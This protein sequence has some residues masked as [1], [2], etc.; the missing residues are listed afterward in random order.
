MKKALSFI[1]ALAM[2][3]CLS[4]TAFAAS[5]DQTGSTSITA[6]VVGPT[7]TIHVPAA[8]TLD[9]TDTGIQ[10]V[11]EVYID[12]IS[13]IPVGKMIEYSTSCNDLSDGNGHTI[14]TKL[15]R[16]D[17]IDGWVEYNSSWANTLYMEMDG[18]MSFV[19]FTWGVQ[20]PSWDDAVPGTYTTTMVFN[21]YID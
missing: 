20:I 19:R 8:V 16:K 5:G 12:G 17:T 14:T 11:G 21:F 9:C 7:Y 10:E 4:V 6:T 2:I 1:L 3:L 18:G 15:M 13:N